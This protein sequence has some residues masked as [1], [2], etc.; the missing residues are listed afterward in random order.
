MA[1]KEDTESV[2]RTAVEEL[3]R[4]YD[5]ITRSFE[6]LRTKA[7]ALLAG[8]VGISSFIFSSGQPQRGIVHGDVPIY[9]IAL[10]GIGIALLFLSALSFLYVSSTAQWVHP[11]DDEDLTN[12]E[13]NFP[14]SSDYLERIKTEYMAA[15]EHCISKITPRAKRFMNGVYMLAVGIAILLLLKYCSGII[16][17]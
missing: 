14:T 13:K 17:V 15:I 11:P 4:A 16:K 10:F 5:A 6:Q 3:R 2:L 9:G 7:L 1:T 12:L 8:E